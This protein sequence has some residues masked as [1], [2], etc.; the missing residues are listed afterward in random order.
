LPSV[1]PQLRNA[2]LALAIVCLAGQVV[3]F[4]LSGPP[5]DPASGLSRPPLPIDVPP[6][7]DPVTAIRAEALHRPLAPATLARHALTILGIALVLV[8]GIAVAAEAYYGTGRWRW[9]ARAATILALYLLL[10]ILD[11]PFR[12]A[13][14]IHHLAF[15]L[16]PMT[17]ADWFRLQT[18]TT[19]AASAVLVLK[20]ILVF[21]ILRIFRKWWWLA[22]PVA[23]F[24]CFEA[25]PEFFGNL[26]VQ[27][28]STYYPLPGGP[29]RD[30]LERAAR[31]AGVDIEFRVEDR[32]RWDTTVNMDLSG[33]ASGRDLV[34]TDTFLDRFTP[35][36][37]ALAFTHELGHH[38]HR[39]P[40]LLR[41][42]AVVFVSFL[43]ACLLACLILRRSATAPDM[44]LQ[45]TITVILCL[46]IA[47]VLFL[48]VD[49]AISRWDERIADRYAL[50]VTG[51]PDHYASL[52]I[53]GAEINLSRLDV[54]G[55]EYF[56]FA[57]YPSLR[58]RL[59]TAEAFR[60]TRPRALE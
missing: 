39:T 34:L 24:L 15:G 51:D 56:V 27:P 4:L 7:C 41:Y 60:N 25:V 9:P 11:L 6:G 23:L 38:L 36:E 28:G 48:P 5:P 40:Y 37:T 2:L 17:W 19:M 47:N 29:H 42:K 3:P 1:C 31:L 30:A 44:G 46:A 58:D 33:H 12:T 43:L 57:R 45:T 32:S 53:K 20:G 16:T 55:W 10:S 8:S 59:R 13:T 21:C 18:A 14:Y 22:T 26:R 50:E 35:E 49:S 52:L 54:P